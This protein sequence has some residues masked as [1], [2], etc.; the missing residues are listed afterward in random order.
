MPVESHILMDGALHVYRACGEPLLAM[1]DLPRQP[2]S[3]ADDQGGEP[4]RRQGFRARLV[5]GALRRRPSAPSRRRLSDK[6][7]G[8]AHSLLPPNRA[9]LGVDGR[10]RP[11]PIGPSFEDAAKAFAQ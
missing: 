2:Q 7:W 11:K 10:R 3:P 5:Y 9:R 1:L 6:P 4:G 8:S